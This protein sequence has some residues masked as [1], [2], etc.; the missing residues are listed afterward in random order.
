MPNLK[1]GSLLTDQD[2]IDEAEKAAALTFNQIF[3]HDG[4]PRDDYGVQPSYRI[5]ACLNVNK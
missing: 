3:S 4:L 5:G 1:G 2:I